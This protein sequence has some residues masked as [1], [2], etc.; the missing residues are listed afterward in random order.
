MTTTAAFLVALALSLTGILYLRFTDEKRRR[1]LGLAP[2]SRRPRSRI[3]AWAIVLLP[4]LV[5]LF[6]GHA[7]AF[8]IWLGSSAVC[9][10]LIVSWR[11]ASSPTRE[12]KIS[13]GA[14]RTDEPSTAV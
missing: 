1:V 4:G 6:T 12:Q 8:L 3:V 9:S 10:W 7:S 2:R 11:G 14:T 5:L 13:E